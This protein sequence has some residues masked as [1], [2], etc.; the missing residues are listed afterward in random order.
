MA[1]ETP[2]VCTLVVFRGNVELA[3]DTRPAYQV[4]KRLSMW[5]AANH[6]KLD[7]M[8]A[9]VY[10]AG[11]PE[12]YAT[13]AELTHPNGDVDRFQMINGRSLYLLNES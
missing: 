7:Q 11:Q 9:S 6:R 3:R 4:G 12:T 2:P 13:R 5:A 10:R 1:K 8:A